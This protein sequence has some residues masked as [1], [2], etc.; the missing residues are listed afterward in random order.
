M[1]AWLSS[2]RT[3]RLDI[4]TGEFVIPAGSFSKGIPFVEKEAAFVVSK[5]ETGEDAMTL[6]DRAGNKL[7][8]P[9]Q[10][11]YY[12]DSWQDGM[13]R[14]A[15]PENEVFIGALNPRGEEIIPLDFKVLTEVAD[16]YTI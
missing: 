7:T 3:G 16:G 12:G 1:R 11:L 2:K 6:I 15:H 13:I 10:Y 14:V 8:E 5:T 9:G 4:K